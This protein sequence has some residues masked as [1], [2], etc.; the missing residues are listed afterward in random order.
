MPV[1]PKVVAVTGASGYIG[2]PLLMQLETNPKVGKIV[3]F[4]RKP[5]AY[6]IRNISFYQEDVAEPI[7]ALLRR[8]RVDTLVHLAGAYS[9]SSAGLDWA[10]ASA[11]NRRILEGTRQSCLQAG[12]K[13]VIFVSSHSVYGAFADTPVPVTEASALRSRRADYLGWASRDDDFLMQTFT[14]PRPEDPAGDDP[15]KVTILRACTV[16]GYSDDHRRAELIFPYRFRGMSENP[17]F[18]FLH[19]VDMA[20]LLETVIEREPEGIF[21]V[22]GEGVVFLRELSEITGRKLS[23]LPVF[24]AYPTAWL[25]ARRGPAVGS[26]WNLNTARFPIIMSTG[27]VK[28]T[29]DYRFSYTSMEALNAFVNYNGL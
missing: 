13:H 1:N 9:H 10:A 2:A 5:L 14:T 4:D 8:H 19:E 22:A 3:A 29:L 25:A 17:A 11:E 23:Q 27:K 24:L 12:V 28:Q 7:Q 21:N 26:A 6:P 16:L 20:Q 15:P 18:Q